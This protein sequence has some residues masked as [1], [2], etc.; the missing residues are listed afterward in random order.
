MTRKK[1]HDKEKESTHTAQSTVNF[2]KKFRQTVFSYQLHS[3]DLKPRNHHLSLCL[4]SG[5]ILST[6]KW[7]TNE[8]SDKLFEVTGSRFP[9]IGLKKVQQHTKCVEHK[10]TYTEKHCIHVDTVCHNCI[11]FFHL[12]LFNCWL[13]TLFCG[14][15][16]FKSSRRH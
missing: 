14:H 1:E 3:P 8:S 9:D 6:S 11:F 15:A 12:C 16:S 5:C 10:D 2:I 13:G 4:N 7:W